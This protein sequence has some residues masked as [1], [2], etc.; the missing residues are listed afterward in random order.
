MSKSGVYI[1]DYSRDI[2]NVTWE[3]QNLSDTDRVQIT[4]LVFHCSIDYIDKYDNYN[5]LIVSDIGEIRKLTNILQNNFIFHFLKDITK[6]VLRNK[7]TLESVIHD[8]GVENKDLYKIFT[9]KFEDWM[10]DNLD[11]DTVLDIINE[12]GI[13]NLRQVDLKYLENYGK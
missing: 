6:D 13:E 5:M 8:R 10:I 3:Y 7:I 11:L 2:N 4:N 12:K 9:T 1:I